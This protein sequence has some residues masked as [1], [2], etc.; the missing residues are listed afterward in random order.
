VGTEYYIYSSRVPLV[1]TQDNNISI[2]TMH[3]TEQTVLSLFSPIPSML[4]IQK[5]RVWLVKFWNIP[6]NNTSRYPQGSNC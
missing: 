3:F 4:E 6:E 5:R 1:Y 2:I